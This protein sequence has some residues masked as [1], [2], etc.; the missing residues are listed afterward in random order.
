M[1]IFKNFLLQT[2]ELPVEDVESCTN[3]LSHHNFEKNQFIVSPGNISGY[4]YFVNKGVLRMYSIDTG[5]KEHIIQFA[6][7]W[8]ILSDRRSTYLNEPSMFYIQAVE[9]SEVVFIK[10]GFMEEI[11][12]TYPTSAAK[13][14]MIL[15]RHIMLM[16]HRVN[17]LLSATAEERYLDFLTTYPGFI[18]RVPLYMIASYLGITPES[19]S[20]VRSEL[21]R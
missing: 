8:W 3:G 17:L 10:K 9:D 13:T 15:N 2:L 12:K 7:E 4:A 11:I 14:T 5:G 1:D 18:N 19:L 16:Q 20:R 6:P 21:S